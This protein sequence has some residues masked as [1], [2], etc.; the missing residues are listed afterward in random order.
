MTEHKE[1]NETPK[2]EEPPVYAQEEAQTAPSASGP[3][4]KGDPFRLFGGGETSPA[5]VPGTQEGRY[6][7]EDVLMNQFCSTSW[8]Q[9]KWRWKQC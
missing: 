3:V 7:I 4:S 5:Y 6:Q 2:E 9:P 1:G 8:F